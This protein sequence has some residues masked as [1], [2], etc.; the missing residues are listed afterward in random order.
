[1]VQVVCSEQVLWSL[2]VCV[3]VPL[4]HPQK[5]IKKL[6]IILDPKIFNVK[7]LQC[8]KLMFSQSEFHY[9]CVVPDET[10]VLSVFVVK[11]FIWSRE[12]EK[13]RERNGV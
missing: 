3:C 9:R 7:V 10:S 13:E 11:L 8:D 6:K 1:M 4:I 12:R 2:G 5:K